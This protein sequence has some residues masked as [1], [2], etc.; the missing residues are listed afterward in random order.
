MIKDHLDL[1]PLAALVAVADSGSF[2]GAARALGYTQSA[3]SHQIAML[4]R[5]LGAPVFERPGGRARVQLTTIGELSYEHA[6]HV[7]AAANALTADVAAALAGTRGTL[8]IGVSQSTGF[9]L[10]SPLAALRRQNPGIEVSII[11]A[12]TAKRLVQLL[13]DGRL[14]V[15]LYINIEPDERVVTMPLFEDTWMLIARQD[16]PVAQ[17]SAVSL[18]VLDGVDMIA[19]H[20]RWRAQAA[21]EEAWRVRGITPRIVYRSDDSLM[22]Q[23][24]VAAGLGWACLGALSVQQLIGSELRRI[25]IRDELPPRTL[26]LCHARDRQLT[27]AASI[28]IDAV[29]AVANPSRVAD[30]PV[31]SLAI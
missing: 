14:D 6:R 12:V 9:M 22:I 19:W 25:A 13:A 10:A 27:P 21:L 2:R 17:G 18:D 26:V 5:R 20:K 4:E 15:G 23:R 8:R 30:Q 29:R 1:R 11:D 24:L 3:I 28:L 16:A 31:G 7:L